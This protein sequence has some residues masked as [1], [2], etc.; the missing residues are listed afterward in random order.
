MIFSVP[1]ESFRAETQLLTYF[2]LELVSNT[3]LFHEFYIRYALS[4]ITL[5]MSGKFVNE[6]VHAQ[7]STHGR[8]YLEVMDL[9]TQKK[10][11]IFYHD[12]RNFGT[13]KFC[14]SKAELNDKLESLGPDIL[15]P[16][17]TTG[18]VFVDII[19]RKKSSDLNI[20]KFLMNQSVCTVRHYPLFT[21]SPFLIT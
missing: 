21:L 17:T 6:K 9:D 2:L 16:A 13:L 15:E 19:S 7:D 14:L 12:M 5:G 4:W 11:K 8:W 20:C 10:T 18:D 3:C 1:C